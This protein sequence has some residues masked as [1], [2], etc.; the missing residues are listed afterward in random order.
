MK[1]KAAVP[2]Y[3]GH[4]QVLGRSPTTLKNVRY[5]LRHL[6][7]FLEK[8]A[9]FDIEALTFDILEG[10]QQELAFYL[11]QKGKLMEIESQGKILSMVKGFT[12]YLKQMDYLVTDP[13]ERIKLP[14]TPMRLPKVILSPKEIKRLLA[15]PDTRTTTGF[16]DRIIL[17]ILYDTAIRRFELAGIK[18]ADLDL[19]AGYIRIRGKGNK[20][21]VVPLSHRVCELVRNYMLFVR[22]CLI[23]NNDNGYLIA[24]RWGG[25]MNLSTINAIVKDSA[26]GAGIKK[27]V[28][29][30]T[31]RHTC[32]T[33]ML[34]AGAPLR[35]IQEL[36]GHACIETT[37]VY[38]RVTIND[39]KK[40]HAKY[41]PSE[42]L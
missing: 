18:V 4:L 3:I 27:K 34:R 25:Q 31:L 42:Q 14:K 2:A 36:L 20:Q 11:T 29:T 40:I 38:T 6:T 5:A 15:A 7:R 33:H 37:Q 16:R 41:H 22:P 30:H 21:R 23:K 13:G 17:E 32:A 10:Y 28:T 26:R 24:G 1:I 35:H 8:E 9:V 39:L 19:D 12:R